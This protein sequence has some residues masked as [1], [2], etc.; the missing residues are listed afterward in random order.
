MNRPTK[1]GREEEAV[2]RKQPR[3]DTT[4][5]STT[6][7]DKTI[8]EGFGIGRR[9]W[10]TLES[11]LLDGGTETGKERL[12]HDR[13][14]ALSQMASN[15]VYASAWRNPNNKSAL[16]VVVACPRR[17]SNADSSSG[18]ERQKGRLSFAGVVAA[19]VFG[20]RD[21]VGCV[22]REPESWDR[23]ASA[24]RLSARCPRW[25]WADSQ[26]PST[27]DG[28]DAKDKSITTA[29][30]DRG[31]TEGGTKS[32][33]GHSGPVWVVRS[34]PRRANERISGQSIAR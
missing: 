31:V 8:Q 21:A 7:R 10:E 27:G 25:A 4:Y 34:I 13:P 28:S 23:S 17:H 6:R 1:T 29:L 2:P 14:T 9:C 3:K 12:S 15:R 18:N 30:G 11:A 32:K 16:E 19:A 26:R 22:Q 5:Q 33:A 20:C 24:L